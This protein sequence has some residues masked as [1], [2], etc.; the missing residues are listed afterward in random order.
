MLKNKY[1]WISVGLVVVALFLDFYF[2][3]AEIKKTTQTVNDLNGNTVSYDILSYSPKYKLINLASTLLYTLGISIAIYFG[4][5]FQMDKI[6][7][8]KDRNELNELQRKINEN[9]FNGV[10]QKL[11]PE[12]L[13]KLMVRD[14]INK[15]IIRRNATWTYNIEETQQGYK[16]TQLI[17]YELENIGNQKSSV[18]IS[19][20]VHHTTLS[21]SH[22]EYFKVI[23]NGTDFIEYDK[24][25]IASRQ[26]PIE[27]GI[28]NVVDVEISPSE[29]IKVVHTV[30]NE[31]FSKCIVDCHFSIYSIIGLKI[32]VDKPINCDFH[33]LGTFTEKL[34][35]YK[36]TPNKIVYDP[37]DGILIGQSV[38]YMI[39]KKP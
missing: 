14:I 33:M 15:S 28:S 3:V 11:V 10:L 32:T 30:V 37:I 20:N 18:P 16:L 13:F 27:K 4:I 21:S 36:P 26:T 2:D 17:Q 22:F 8:T 34:K 6:E 1:F 19:I 29:V 23:K 24:A 9:I 31:Y 38:I 35:S 25:Q 5:E 7:K 39:E 12:E